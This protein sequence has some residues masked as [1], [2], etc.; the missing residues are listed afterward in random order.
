M[1]KRR[2]FTLIEV[3]AALALIIVLTLTL[4]V[5]IQGQVKQAQHRQDQTRIETVNA[6]VAIAYEQ[7]DRVDSDFSS[8]DSLVKAGIITDDQQAQLAKI[9]SYTASPPRFKL[10]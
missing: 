6:Q 1:K 4:V 10:K 7:T 5:T 9:A 2:A 8:V 3:L